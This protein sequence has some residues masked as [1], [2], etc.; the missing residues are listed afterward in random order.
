MKKISSKMFSFITLALMSMALLSTVAQAQQ[1]EQPPAFVVVSTVE[2]RDMVATAIVPGTVVSREDARIS[3]EV[4]GRLLTIV[5]IGTRVD[6]GDVLAKID[7]TRLRLQLDELAAQVERVKAKQVFLRA[8]EKRLAKLAKK[9]LASSTQYE[10]V[11]SDRRIADS[12]L[13]IARARLEQT[14]DDLA[15]ASITAPFPG[16]VVERLSNVGE[17]LALGSEVLRLVNTDMLEVVA[18]APLEYLPFSHIGEKLAVIHAQQNLPASIRTLVAVG[19]ERSHVF[20]LRLDLPVGTMLPVGQTLRVR[21][22]V[23][24]RAQVLAVPR[25]ALVL[26]SKGNSVFVISADNKARQVW[27]ETGISE[28]DWIEVRGDLQTDEQV[29]IRG[30]ERLRPDQQVNIKST[31]ATVDTDSLDSDSLDF[32]GGTDG[33]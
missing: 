21:I 11:V 32:D 2:L 9:N 28:A 13:Q 10:Q 31:Q 18:R 12:D 27:V 22:P 8:E 30:G 33:I 20:E 19:N 29:V 6:K 14:S 16:V 7:A 23:A 5:D 24:A 26:R 3:A 25:D 17:R 4:S 1:Q 15:R